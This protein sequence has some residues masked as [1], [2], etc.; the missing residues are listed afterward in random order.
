VLGKTEAA[1]RNWIKD[2]LLV[3]AS[4]K[5]YLISGAE[6]RDYLPAKYQ[7]S[8]TTLAP[9]ELY[10]LLC[11]AGRKPWGRLAKAAVQ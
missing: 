4:M 8:K 3:M 7:K 6:L 2:G 11:R 1:I 10:C 9:D 5:P